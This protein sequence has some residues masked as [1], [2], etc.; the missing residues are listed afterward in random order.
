MAVVYSGELFGQNRLVEQN[1][2][3]QNGG[4]NLFA[5]AVDK[6]NFEKGEREE[7]NGALTRS[8]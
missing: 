4:G 8:L 3:T 2:K 5:A 7:T 1:E 6:T